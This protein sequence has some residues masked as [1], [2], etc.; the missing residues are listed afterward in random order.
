M[1]NDKNIY[2]IHRYTR[3]RIH[4]HTYPAHYTTSKEKQITRTV[5]VLKRRQA[6]KKD[7]RCL[8]LK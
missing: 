5:Y 4:T 6:M 3:A 8:G 1:K 7:I 2:I